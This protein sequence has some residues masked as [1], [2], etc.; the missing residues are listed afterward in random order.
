MSF[1]HEEQFILSEI[2]PLLEALGY[3]VVDLK[4]KGI[5]GRLQ[6]HLTVHKP[7]GITV[8]DCSEIYKTVYPRLEVV[9]END[10]I[11]LE[12]ASPGIGRV[13]KDTREYHI[14]TGRPVS[15]LFEGESDWI[16]GEIQE[17]RED[18]L[19]FVHGDESNTLRFEEIRKA[20]LL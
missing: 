11:S 14:F 6:V 2:E 4:A 7:D 9:L 1:T 19:I 3:T 12:V 8:D 18:S 13:M 10:D 5:K 16:E 17:V 20:K 15:L